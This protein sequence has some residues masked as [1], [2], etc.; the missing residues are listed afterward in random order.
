MSN[1]I[2]TDPGTVAAGDIQFFD[3]IQPPLKTDNY[4]LSAKQTI[5]NVV[6]SG[7]NPEYDALKKLT[8]DGPRFVLQPSNIHSLFPPPN[9]VGNFANFLPNIVFNDFSLPWSRAID[10]GKTTQN[11]DTP[12]MGLLTLYEAEYLETSSSRKISTPQTVS[13]SQLVNPGAGVLPPDL[14]TEFKGSDDEK[15]TVIDIDLEYFQAIAPKLEELKY[16]S[17]ARAVNTDGKVILN[18]DADGCFSLC[19]GNRVPGVGQRNMILLVSFEGHQDHL[20][21]AS[22]TGSFSKIRLVHLGSWEFTTSKFDREFLTMMEAICQ[23]GNGGTSLIQLST[24]QATEKNATAKEALDIGYVALQN[25]MRVGENATSWYRG[26]LVPS[27]TKRGSSQPQDGGNYGPYI[28]S[29]H[30]MHYDPGTGIFNHAYSAAWQ[31]GRLLALSDATFAQGMFN[32]RAEYLKSIIN[33]AKQKK[34]QAAAASIQGEMSGAGPLNLH[35]ATRSF[36]S[37]AFKKVDW[38]TL[39]TR[40]QKMLTDQF[41]AVFTE[42]EKKAIEENDEDPLLKLHQKIK[43]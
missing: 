14:G 18:M 36:F 15:V 2:I 41:P 35:A 8:I 31:I 24:D 27:P 19:I 26:P 30:A 20:N 42:V 12:W 11:E 4:T 16:L 40:K 1:S 43:Q 17:H 39:K 9:Q 22:I 25:K 23:P 10:P 6:D 34:T 3:S 32:W 28:Y 7:D 33:Q 38:D 13:T 37:D 21:S 5:Q 29:D